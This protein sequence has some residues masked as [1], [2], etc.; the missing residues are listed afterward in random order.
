LGILGEPA[1]TDMTGRDLRV[2]PK[3]KA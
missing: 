2:V 1:P 3:A